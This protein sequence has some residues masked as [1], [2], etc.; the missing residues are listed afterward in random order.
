MDAQGRARFEQALQDGD[1]DEAA[2]LCTATPGSEEQATWQAGA[3]TDLGCAHQRAGTLSPALECW[4][5]AVELAAGHLGLTNP[6]ALSPALLLAR[7]LPAGDEADAQEYLELALSIDPD[8][9]LPVEEVRIARLA[10][11]GD[12]T[13]IVSRVEQWP[14]PLPMPLAVHRIL[15]LA[16]L[17]ERGRAEQALT[18]LREA[19]DDGDPLHATLD[20]LEQSLAHAPVQPRPELA[21]ALEAEALTAARAGDQPRSRELCQQA[22]EVRGTEPALAVLAWARCLEALNRPKGAQAQLLEY[23]ALHRDEP[24][25][26]WTSLQAGCR[27]LVGQG[28]ADAH[29]TASWLVA[30]AELSA[31]TRSR[32]AAA[33]ELLEALL[34]GRTT[35]AGVLDRLIQLGAPLPQVPAL[36]PLLEEGV[37]GSASY[38]RAVASWDPSTPLSSLPAVAFKCEAERAPRAAAHWQHRRPLL[39]LAATLLARDAVE[40]Q[41]WQ[42]TPDL[43]DDARFLATVDNTAS[44]LV[45]CLLAPVGQTWLLL[46]PGRGEGWRARI[47][48][49]LS[50][51][52]LQMV[53]L[54]ALGRA[55]LP[56]AAVRRARGACEPALTVQLPWQARAWVV[57]G[58]EAE[59]RWLPARLGDAA[60]LDGQPVLVWDDAP[61]PVPCTPLRAPVPLQVTLEPLTPEAL[62]EA[63]S[64]LETA[65]QDGR[66][67][68]V[69]WD[70]MAQAVEAA[71][72]SGRNAQAVTLARS[73]V[74]RLTGSPPSVPRAR[75]CTLLARAL[76]AADGNP[77]EVQAAREEALRSWPL[78]HPERILALLDQARSLRRQRSEGEPRRILDQARSL[79]RQRS[80]GEPRRILDQAVAQAEALDGTMLVNALTARAVLRGKEGDLSGAA[81]DAERATTLAPDARARARAKTVWGKLL[82]AMPDQLDRAIE[83][84]EQAHT[85]LRAEL[86]PEHPELAPHLEL[87]ATFH[88]AAGEAG[89]ASACRRRA[90]ALQRLRDGDPAQQAHTQVTQWLRQSAAHREAGE[91]GPA[92][93]CLEQALP[94]V[95]LHRGDPSLPLANLLVAMAELAAETN[96]AADARLWLS[97]AIGVARAT[98]GDRHSQV[99]HLLLKAADLNKASLRQDT[100]A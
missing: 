73:L 4:R 69:W 92:L 56:D 98:L 14:E 61:A 70:R 86:G 78:E 96:R 59:Q 55:D 93:E 41:R 75:A 64:A 20:R 11:A 97:R 85:T 21:R 29:R 19:L 5:Q 39:S 12:F 71:L 43:V 44:Y 34:Q 33:S 80:E 6:A 89:L 36:W 27:V 31:D 1:L 9:Q 16:R 58:A 47:D 72:R 83:L 30:L 67:D 82:G 13:G 49:G 52:A 15:A 88:Q 68:A 7:H 42:Q 3:L 91:P 37:R 48:G 99:Q 8:A 10:R 95:A 74:D 100:T 38:A 81:E 23:L 66:A 26:S 46:H 60:R 65:R 53:V 63:L 54:D 28:D 76:E 94:L 50:F 57:P 18:L 87:L 62:Q 24:A 32:D 35:A 90:S 40:R 45:D 77:L 84:L 22:R 25:P 79:R 51:E 17:G 2:R